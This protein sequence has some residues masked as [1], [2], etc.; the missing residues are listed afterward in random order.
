MCGYRRRPLT[1][2]C[3]HAVTLIGPSL[4]L[5]TDANTRAST[6]WANGSVSASATC[7][8]SPRA[9]PPSATSRAATLMLC[10][11]RAS[12]TH[13]CLWSMTVNAASHGDTEAQRAGAVCAQGYPVMQL[14]AQ[15]PPQAWA[16]PLCP[17]AAAPPAPQ[18]AA[19]QIATS[20]AGASSLPWMCVTEASSW[21]P[22]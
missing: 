16:V 17:G 5:P 6:A 12:G 7:K 20:T 9:T 21:W 2:G 18:S 15:S 8:P 19:L 22:L 3:G 14:E 11:T 10:S 4:L 13:G 1:P